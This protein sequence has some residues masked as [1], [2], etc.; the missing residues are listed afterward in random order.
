MG[1]GPVDLAPES[2]RAP[3]RWKPGYGALDSGVDSLLNFFFLRRFDLRYV[4]IA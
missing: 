3:C 1:C 2:T 4:L